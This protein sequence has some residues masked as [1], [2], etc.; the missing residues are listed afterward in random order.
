ME[1]DNKWCR[2]EYGN[3]WAASISSQLECQELCLKTLS[4]VGI[5]Y[6]YRAEMSNS[7]FM[8]K[9]DVLYPNAHGF[10]F[11]RKPGKIITGH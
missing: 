4:C 2:T 1:V 7:C 5:S 9:H 6:S 10:A 11:Y 8:C 3:D